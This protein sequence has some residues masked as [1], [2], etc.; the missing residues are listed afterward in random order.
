MLRPWSALDWPENH[1][2]QSCLRSRLFPGEPGIG[3]NSPR[4]SPQPL[5]RRGDAIGAGQERSAAGASRG[6]RATLSGAIQAGSRTANAEIARAALDRGTDPK[7]VLDTMT[8]AVDE[9][10]KRLQEGE[11]CA[12]CAH[13]RERGVIAMGRLSNLKV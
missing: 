9:V 3:A 2:P 6:S 7:E 10:G 12:R 5:E 11:L 8:S 1:Q 4:A 13:R